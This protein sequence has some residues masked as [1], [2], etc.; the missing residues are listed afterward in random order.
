[1]TV[2]LHH[3]LVVAALL[4]ALGVFA[5]LTRRNAIAMLMGI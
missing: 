4:F 1:M 2:G 5:I 3:Y